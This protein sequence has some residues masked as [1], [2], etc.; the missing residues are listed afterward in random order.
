MQRIITMGTDRVAKPFSTAMDVTSMLINPTAYFVTKGAQKT[1]A[2]GY[3]ALSGKNE[4]G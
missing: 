4:Y 3:D 2:Y 1:A